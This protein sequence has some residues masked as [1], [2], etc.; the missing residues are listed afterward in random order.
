M[1]IDFQK[2]TNPAAPTVI[3]G[4]LVECV[5]CYKYL[6]TVLDRNLKFNLNTTAI[7]KKG[8]QILYFLRRLGALI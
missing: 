5:D 4:S 3:K 8:L 1:A 6:G 2:T 7:C